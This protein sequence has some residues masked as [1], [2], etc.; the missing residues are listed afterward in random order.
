MAELLQCEPKEIIFTSGGSEADNQAVL[1]AAEAG[2]KEGHCH[3]VSTQVEHHAVV[4]HAL[5]RARQQGMEIELLPTDDC[6]RVTAAEVK[7]AIRPETGLVSVMYANNEIGTVMPVQEIADV[8]CHSDVLFH[9]DAVQAVGHLSVQFHEIGADLLSLSA[10]K[11]HGPRG[12]GALLVR[13][14]IHASRLIEGGQQERNRRAGTENLPGIVGMVT[15]LQE[16]VRRMNQ[17]SVR[18]RKLRDRLIAGLLKIPGTT[19]NGPDPMQHPQE[20]LPGNVNLS[21]AGIDGESL[22]LLLDDHGICVSSGS[23]CASGSIDPSHVILAIGRSRELAYGSVRIS[24]GRDNTE[25]DI[26]RL[27]SVIRTSV[28]RLREKGN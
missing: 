28:E 3:L 18:I 27:Q 26:D 21:F 9:T 6:G 10:H 15:A 19:L 22:L 17:D 7:R 4:L 24:L 5:D 13:K 8:C 11:F 14:G 1:T 20:R 25:R 2:R 23:A 12:V 16:S